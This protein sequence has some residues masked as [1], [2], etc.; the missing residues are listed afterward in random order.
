MCS[1]ASKNDPFQNVGPRDV[2]YPLFD[3]HTRVCKY[4]I[5]FF[6]LFLK[7]ELY[8]PE[9]LVKACNSSPSF[10]MSLMTWKLIAMFC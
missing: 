9:G 3:I 4:I 5:V 1:V 8:T 2:E 10:H 7:H 6:D